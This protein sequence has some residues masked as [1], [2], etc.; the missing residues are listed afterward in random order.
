MRR[1]IV[2]A[3]VSLDGVM[4]AP[5]GPDE[6]REGGFEFGGWVAPYFDETLGEAI[7]DL[8]ARPFALL[9]GRKTYEIFAAHWPY[10]DEGPDKSLA[11]LFN[12]ATKY[13]A[14]RTH[15]NL[16]WAHSVVLHDAAADV[17]RL[18]LGDGPDIVVQ[19][20]SVLNQTLM[21]HGLIDEIRLFVFPVVLGRGKRF[22]GEEVAPGAYELENSRPAPSGVTVNVFRPAGP[23]QTGSFALAEPTE[24][25]LARRENWRREEGTREAR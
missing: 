15:D 10:I 3:M 23:V 2:G 13:V 21:N 4:Q 25:E 24:A 20:S 8:F 17:Q 16:D 5:G 12:E 11:V 14:T 6:D 1:L 18:K 19:G 9:L 7:G 22:F